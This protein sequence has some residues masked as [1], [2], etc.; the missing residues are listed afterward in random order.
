MTRVTVPASARPGETHR[1]S[2]A[3]PLMSQQS[4]QK[5]GVPQ[6][7]HARPGMTQDS[8]PAWAQVGQRT[9]GS[10]WSRLAAY[11]DGRRWVW[12]ST[13]RS[14]AD[15][16][17]GGREIRVFWTRQRGE[18]LRVGEVLGGVDVQVARDSRVNH[19]GGAW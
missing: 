8:L 19:I 14:R 9:P 17:A 11:S 13:Y 4:S 7:L 1:G 16:G 10:C 5:Q 2:R 18:R 3:E 6:V 12:R 15:V